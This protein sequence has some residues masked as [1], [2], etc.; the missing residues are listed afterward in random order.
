MSLL[1]FLRKILLANNEHPDQMPHYVASDLGL[2]CLPFYG[3]SC[4]N[5]LKGYTIYVS[6][7]SQKL[8]LFD[9][10]WENM[11]VYPYTVINSILNELF[12][13]IYILEESI[14]NFR[15]VGLC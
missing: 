14:F 13:S 10:W 3:F 5:G 11:K 4:N 12:G 15:G 2:H 9:K 1:F 7:Q 8:T 6:K